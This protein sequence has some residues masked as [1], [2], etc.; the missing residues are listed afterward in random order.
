MLPAGMQCRFV[1][2]L[3]A[4]GLLPAFDTPWAAA[5]NKPGD[6]GTTKVNSKL[7][8]QCCSP[9]VVVVVVFSSVFCVFALKWSWRFVARL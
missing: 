5:T 8:F 2:A 7:V 6:T 4:F 3:P 9:F 1:V